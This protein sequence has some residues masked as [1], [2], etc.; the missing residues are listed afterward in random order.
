MD[1]LNGSGSKCFSKDITDGN[2]IV[3]IYVSC[4]DEFG[5]E[6]SI[7]GKSSHMTT[8]TDW[9]AS[10]EDAIQHGMDAILREGIEEFY[11]NLEFGCLDEL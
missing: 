8:W 4:C 6:L 2:K 11:S 3:T 7:I 10:S 1:D 5:W 9:F